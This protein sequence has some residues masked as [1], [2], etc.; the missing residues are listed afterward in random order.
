[1][2]P[3]LTDSDRKCYT[4]QECKYSYN[5]PQGCYCNNSNCISCESVREDCKIG[6]DCPHGCGCDPHSGKCSSPGL[7]EGY[8]P[9]RGILLSRE[10]QDFWERTETWVKP[11]RQVLRN[12]IPGL[13]HEPAQAG[14]ID[15]FEP[16]VQRML[17][18]IDEKELPIEIQEYRE[19]YPLLCPICNP[20]PPREG[21]PGE[22]EYQRRYAERFRRLHAPFAAAAPPLLA[23]AP[24]DRANYPLIP[25]PIHRQT[26]ESYCD[27]CANRTGHDCGRCGPCHVQYG[28]PQNAQT[29]VGNN[30]YC[31]GHER[32]YPNQQYRPL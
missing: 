14:P 5:C 1:M 26:E 22:R 23:P 10:E 21:A 9:R 7:S 4:G 12:A 15:E 30:V 13:E 24:L 20:I 16:R 27:M 31:T 3:N 17:I 19:R 11:R 6:L 2:N 32:I 25:L 29:D 18:D 8:L 28:P